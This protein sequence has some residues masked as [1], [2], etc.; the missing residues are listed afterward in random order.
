MLVPSTPE[1]VASDLLNGYGDIIATAIYITEDRKQIADFV[2]A[3][4]SKHDVVVSGPSSP[5]LTGL[6]DLSGKQVYVFKE[7]LAWEKLAALDQTLASRKED[8]NKLG[9]CRTTVWNPKTS[10]K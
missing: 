7:S 10:W 5:A 2:P 3:A 6:G 1:K 8:R 9:A 4:S